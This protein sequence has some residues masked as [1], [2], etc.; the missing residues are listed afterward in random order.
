[1]VDPLDAWGE[2]GEVRYA[3]LQQVSD[4]V[5]SVREQLERVARAHVLRE[6]QDTCCGQRWRIVFAARSPSSAWVGGMRCRRSRRRVGV[7]RRARA[8]PRRWRRTWRRQTLPGEQRGQPVAEGHRVVGEDYAHRISAR[9][10]VS[11]P[12]GLDTISRP[13]SASTRSVRPRSPDQPPPRP[14]PIPS[15]DTSTISRFARATP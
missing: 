9:T 12:G 2:L 7:A 1:V 13:P 11:R 8:V 3:L 10:V 5:G 6:H 15:S 14:P 4:P